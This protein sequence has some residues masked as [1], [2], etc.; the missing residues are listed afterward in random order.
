MKAPF[1]PTPPEFLNGVKFLVFVIILGLFGCDNQQASEKEIQDE[2]LKDEDFIA[3]MANAYLLVYYEHN[4]NSTSKIREENFAVFDYYYKN[5]NNRYSDFYSN[6]RLAMANKSTT[7]YIKF[8]ESL[9]ES[10]YSLLPLESARIAAYNGASICGQ[11]SCGNSA[12][13]NTTLGCTAGAGFA[14]L[15]CLRNNMGHCSEMRNAIIDECCN[16]FCNPS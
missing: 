9:G 3:M 14:E 6:A 4:E 1:I 16:S 13:D 15:Y 5:L 7:S 8:T 11:E 10:I 2:I 12:Q